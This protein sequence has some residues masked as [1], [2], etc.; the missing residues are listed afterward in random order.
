[1]T[2]KPLVIFSTQGWTDLWVSKHWIANEF[3]KDREVLFVEPPLRFPPAKLASGELFDG[4]VEKIKDNLY[5]LTTFTFPFPFRVPSF[6]RPLWRY[7]IRNQSEEAIN[8]FSFNQF[9]VLRNL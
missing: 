1:M 8:Q 7:P 6:S 9:D 4:K 3:A 2:T 5:K